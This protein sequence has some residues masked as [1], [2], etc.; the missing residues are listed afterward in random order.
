ML[1]LLSQWGCIA[2]V[3]KRFPAGLPELRNEGQCLASL[4]SS[5]EEFA[6]TE[7]VAEMAWRLVH[8]LS[9]LSRARPQLQRECSRKDVLFFRLCSQTTLL[10]IKGNK[11]FTQMTNWQLCG[12]ES[13][14]LECRFRAELSFQGPVL[15]LSS[16][17]P[18]G[19]R[20]KCS[21]PP[22]VILKFCG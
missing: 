22:A 18:E 16:E 1:N 4:G 20:Q 21:F 3:R 17:E 15:I 11:I 8:S 7:D 14:G 2:V 19:G 12:Q 10:L 13:E 6:I 9:T 5:V